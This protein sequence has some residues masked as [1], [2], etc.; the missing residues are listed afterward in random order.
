[1]AWSSGITWVPPTVVPQATQVCPEC[2][3][4]AQPVRRLVMCSACEWS[5]SRFGWLAPEPRRE[6]SLEELY[7]VCL[8]V[9]AWQRRA[10]ERPPETPDR[11]VELV[12]LVGTE[13]VEDLLELELLEGLEPDAGVELDLEVGDEPDEG[14]LLEVLVG[15][16]P[17]AAGLV[18][19][20]LLDGPEPEDGQWK[21]SKKASKRL[22][23]PQPQPPA[24]WGTGWK[25][26]KK[27]SKR[28][29]AHG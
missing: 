11:L 10:P 21:S 4:T 25:T 7:G 15:P 16:E 13:P 22:A 23:G 20:E 5:G 19:L 24:S 2:G 1:M 26:S 3:A 6:P 17:E 12:V 18:E 9:L 8:A 28:E 27:A 29:V 14:E